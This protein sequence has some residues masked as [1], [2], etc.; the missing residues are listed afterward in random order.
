MCEFEATEWGSTSGQ[1][2]VTILI[3]LTKVVQRGFAQHAAIERVITAS[4]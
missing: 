3:Y 2:H 4:D 1:L